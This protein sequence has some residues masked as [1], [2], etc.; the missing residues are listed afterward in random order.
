MPAFH[1]HLKRR[2]LSAI[3]MWVAP[4]VCCLKW[5]GH[6]DTLTRKKAPFLCS[7]LNAGS[8]FMSQGIER[9]ESFVETLEKDIGPSTITTRGLTSVSHLKS[10]VE[11]KPS[12]LD[13]AWIL[14]NINTNPN[15]PV[16][17]ERDPGCPPQLLGVPIALSSL[18]ENAEGSHSTLQD[19]WCF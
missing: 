11:I 18:K 4:W 9:S 6:L 17:V 15:I 8:P 10:Y 12:K 5:N 7:D 1:K 16:E 2:L 3:D 13:D 14:L 19:S